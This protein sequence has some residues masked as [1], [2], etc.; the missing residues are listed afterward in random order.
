MNA[1]FFSQNAQ[2]M[3]KTQIQFETVGLTVNKAYL[4]DVQQA[5]G[6]QIYKAIRDSLPLSL[7]GG[8]STTAPAPSFQDLPFE[9]QIINRTGN[10]TNLNLYGL[11][12][13]TGVTVDNGEHLYIT[14]PYIE[15]ND[16]TLYWREIQISKRGQMAINELTRLYPM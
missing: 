12:R 10:G 4:N 7:H 6:Y 16:P 3:A 15:P 11:I 1:I 13:P 5:T 2:K 14:Y 9:I 8:T